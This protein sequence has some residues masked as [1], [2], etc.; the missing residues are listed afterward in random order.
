VLSSVAVVTVTVGTPDTAPLLV[1]V[2]DR[3]DL[4]GAPMAAAMLDEGLRARGA[5]AVVS[6]AGFHGAER[7]IDEAAVV[8][9]A[10]IGIDV[11]GYSSRQFAASMVDDADLILTLTARDLREA[12]LVD[13]RAWRSSFVLA[14]L[15][16]RAERAGARGPSTP[17]RDWLHELR[18][19]RDTSELARDDAS[20]TR[21]DAGDVAAV[22]A[23]LRELVDRLLRQAFGPPSR[24][25][26]YDLRDVSGGR[27]ATRPPGSLST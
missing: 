1:L 15:V 14:A 10:Q 22:S 17:V 5:R 9:M 2:L 7:P 8:A 12:V 4:V 11:A 18:G 6:S 19:Q 3:T 13:P 25:A 23:E 21:Y 16:D 20:G 24:E 26:P 27:V